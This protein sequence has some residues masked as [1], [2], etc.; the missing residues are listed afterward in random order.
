MYLAG[1]KYAL[2]IL[3]SPG[4]QWPIFKHSSRRA[5]PAA[6]W[7]APSTPPPPQRASLAA[8]TTA[9]T[10]NVV[11]SPT[12]SF[13]RSEV[14]GT[15]RVPDQVERAADSIAPGCSLVRDIFL[16]LG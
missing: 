3:A 1:S 10:G 13:K 7:I 16:V 15:A 4:G 5:G 14:V 9:S 11:M 6:R 2:V 8:V 12:M